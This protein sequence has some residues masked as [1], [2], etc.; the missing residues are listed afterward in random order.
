MTPH[1]MT[2]FTPLASMALVVD[3]AAMPLSEMVTDQPGS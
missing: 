2:V 1:E 3:V